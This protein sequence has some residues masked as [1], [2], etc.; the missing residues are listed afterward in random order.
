MVRRKLEAFDDKAK[1]DLPP[2]S[3]LGDQIVSVSLPLDTRNSPRLIGSEHV[4]LGAPSP[5]VTIAEVEQR[6]VDNVVFTDFRK[7]IGKAF[8]NYFNENIRFNMDDE[9]HIR[10]RS[11]WDYLTFYL[12]DNTV[13]D[14]ESQL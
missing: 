10:S 5:S 14:A 8:S 13:Q 7:K 9:V 2:G 11:H 1:L 4:S 6:C 3:D 12:I